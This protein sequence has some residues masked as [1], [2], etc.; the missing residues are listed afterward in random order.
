MAATLGLLCHE[1]PALAGTETCVLQLR[2][3][4]PK[5]QTVVVTRDFEL[6]D[7]SDEGSVLCRQLLCLEERLS[8]QLL[9]SL[10]EDSP[11]GRLLACRCLSTLLG[12]VGSGLRQE[13]LNKIYP[14]TSRQPHRRTRRNARVCARALTRVYLSLRRAGEASG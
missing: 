5:Q 2:L 12:L 1:E 9:S 13:A 10:D 11:M 14:G 7:L 8:P 6:Y 4:S 3:F